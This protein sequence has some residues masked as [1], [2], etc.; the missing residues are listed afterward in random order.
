MESRS[1]VPSPIYSAAIF[2]A[3]RENLTG[4]LFEPGQDGYAI[5]ATPWN[6]AT[7]TSPAAVA[8]VATAADVQTA[9]RFA[10]Q[11][12]LPVAVQATGHGIASDL[13]GALLIHTGRL[14]E[15]TIN[16]NG[17]AR[18]GAGVAWKTVLESAQLHGLTG[19]SGSAPGVSV[20]G[21]ISGGGLGPMAR[22]YGAASD[23][24]R[25]FEV[26]TGDGE[27][28]HVSA[29][30]D[31]DLFWGLRGGKGSLGIVTAIDFELLPLANVYGGAIFFDGADAET[32]LH[33][34]AQWCPAL[35]HTAT[36]SLALMQLPPMPGVPEPLAGK[37]TLAVRFVFAGGEDDGGAWL[38]PLRTAAVPLIDAVQWMPASMIG[39]VHSDPEDGMPATESTMLLK[40]FTVDTVKALLAAAGPGSGSPQLL[41]EVRQLGG[42]FAEE[43]EVASALC[44]REAAFN[45][46]TIGA[47][48][49]PALPAM[50]E[51]AR[52]VLDALKPWA[53]GG[54]LPNFSASAGAAG[55]A[56][57]YT[58]D[59]LAKLSRLAH[60][61][62]PHGLFRLGQ[63][64]A[65]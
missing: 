58:P 40:E 47:G 57:N 13:D 3:L 21:Y 6:L 27:L 19:L 53:F 12:G 65:R 25:S 52:S 43:P 34:W 31:P 38:Q 20:A 50:A 54:T 46:H 16:P 15:C 49:P 44:H 7:Q 33:A 8:Q 48:A 9:V 32:L 4:S 2:S 35:P 23:L 17:W 29:D 10:A 26:V 5:L 62:D 51:H 63:V 24:V 39:M 59:A 36:T 55:F 37:F 11:H 28:R 42:V 60:H 64:P 14:N 61:Y 56:A 22:T 1:E 41:V 18:T 45:V 30:S